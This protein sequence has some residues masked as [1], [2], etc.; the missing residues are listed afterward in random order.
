MEGDCYCRQCGAEITETSLTCEC[1]EEVLP[2]DNF[3]HACGSSFS[4]EVE[5]VNED[6]HHEEEEG[7]KEP[8]TEEEA[9]QPEQPQF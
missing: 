8:D 6:E 2:N 4:G 9:P 1:G 7:D 3:C 5:T